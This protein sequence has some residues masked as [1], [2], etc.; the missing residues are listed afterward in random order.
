MGKERKHKTKIFLE[1]TTSGIIIYV[2]TDRHMCIYKQ[3]Q[4]KHEDK[5]VKNARNE[6]KCYSSKENGS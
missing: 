5:E 6:V 3:L 4:H 2:R 1:R